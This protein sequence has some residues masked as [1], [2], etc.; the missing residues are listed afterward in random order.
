MEGEV[1]VS[2]ENK[3]KGR[4][5]RIC[6]FCGSRVRY[7]SSFSDAALDL[8]ELLVILFVLLLANS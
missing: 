6:V 5:R 7:R 2:A 8:G 1:E 4:F 3:Q